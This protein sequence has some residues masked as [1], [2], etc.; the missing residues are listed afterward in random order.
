MSTGRFIREAVRSGQ[1]RPQYLGR[2]TTAQI[3]ALVPANYRSGTTV[4]CTDGVNAEREYKLQAGAFGVDGAANKV[5]SRTS[6]D[7]VLG[8]SI[9]AQF[10]NVFSVASARSAGVFTL[11]KNAGITG[12]KTADMLARVNTDIPDGYARCWLLECTN[13]ATTGVTPGVHRANMVAIIETLIARKITPVICLPAPI[14]NGFAAQV[15]VMRAIDWLLAQKYGLAVYDPWR[16]HRQTDGTWTPG[17]SGDTVHPLTTTTVPEAGEVLRSQIASG[18]RVQ[19]SPGMNSGG[20][21]MLTNA[22]F[23]NVTGN[24]PSGWTKAGPGAA[25]TAPATDVLGQACTIT[26]TASATS[27]IFREILSGFS[28]GD[29]IWLTG[30]AMASGLSTAV[31]RIYMR[32][33]GATAGG[34]LSCIWSKSDFPLT[35]NDARGFIPPG[36]TKLQLFSELAPF[37]TGVAT[38]SGAM[39]SSEIQAFNATTMLALA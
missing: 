34:D 21:G 30:Q 18:A 32:F 26:N 6:S 14:S 8:N 3:A 38:C 16:L 5:V 12:N 35:R 10:P 9:A 29:E 25:A 17:A 4:T 19:L 23:V 31:A 7:A 28:V 33:F 37:G 36:T 2:M 24:V 1:F 39:A 11:D 27:Y 15:D 22:C 13:D 20:A